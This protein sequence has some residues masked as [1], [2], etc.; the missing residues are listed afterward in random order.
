MPGLGLP[1]ESV[2]LGV[3][4]VTAVLT[5]P[6]WAWLARLL[7]K[8]VAYIIGGAIGVAVLLALPLVEPEQYVLVVP[9]AATIGVS[10]GAAHVLPDAIFPDVVD[11]DEL[12]TGTRH[13]G[14]YYGVKNFIRKLTSAVA[15]FL[16]LQVLGWLGYQSPPEGAVEFTQPAR[17]LFGM[18]ILA[19]PLAA[20]VLG[21]A[22]AVAR[23]YP[24]N[25][26][27]YNRVRRLLLRRQRRESAWRAEE[28][29][30]GR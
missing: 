12:R 28:A 29:R 9:L 1:I 2:V 26:R 19:G 17:A 13:E 3:L 24:L 15:I 21:S 8:N 30:A 18:R 20:L 4:H 10:V 5:L 6:L 22:V 11:W 27:R 25:R 23:F 16:A 7:N 14:I